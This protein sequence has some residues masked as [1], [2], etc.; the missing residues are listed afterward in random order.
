M[1]AFQ[2]GAAREEL[3]VRD[4]DA[5]HRG[6]VVGEQGSEGAPDDFGAV[7]DGDGAAVEAIPIRQ[8]GIINPQVFED[9]Y[10]C[11]RG[12]GEDAL[13]GLGGVEEADV[14]VEVED[15]AVGEAFDVF[16]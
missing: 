1:S 15:V 10:S 6:A 5:V 13:Q 11:E 3:H 14:L 7:D 12:A 9:F 4:V 8:N 2:P 16:V